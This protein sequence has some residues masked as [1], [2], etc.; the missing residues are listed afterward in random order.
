MRE[1]A[2][3]LPHLGRHL[4]TVKAYTKGEA[5]AA[6]KRMFKERYR[7]PIGYKVVEIK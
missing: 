3:D 6:F 4:K 2:L 1:Y 5:R 7:L